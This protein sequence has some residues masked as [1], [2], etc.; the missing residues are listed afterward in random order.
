MHVV[1]FDHPQAKD[2]G[3][4]LHDEITEVN[5]RPVQ[6]RDSFAKEYGQAKKEMP[7]D[8]AVLRE[9]KAPKRKSTLLGVSSVSRNSFMGA[10]SNDSGT[11]SPQLAESTTKGTTRKLAVPEKKGSPGA[12]K[13]N[14]AS[15]PGAPKLK[16]SG[17]KQQ[18]RPSKA[19]IDAMT[20]DSDML[21]DIPLAALPK[22]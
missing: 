19:Y 8:F 5:G 10:A 1:G 14:A 21:G 20:Q 16:P 9:F 17:G 22:E 3:W 18:Q 15:S 13:T 2:F 7:I 6:S 11:K 12:A 4:Q